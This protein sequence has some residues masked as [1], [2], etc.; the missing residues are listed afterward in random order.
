MQGTRKKRGDR[1]RTQA[2]VSRCS[3]GSGTYEACSSRP[4]P[5]VHGKNACIDDNQADYLRP[6]IPMP[7]D[8]NRSPTSAQERQAIHEGHEKH[9]GQEGHEG[10]HHTIKGK[11][12]MKGVT[13][14][15]MKGK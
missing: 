10:S 2:Y 8:A 4:L 13:M 12:G 1:K 3:L 9:K 14:K 11:K 6:S 7:L 15:T 5:V